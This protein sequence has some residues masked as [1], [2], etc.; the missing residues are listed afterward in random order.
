MNGILDP[1]LPTENISRLE[2]LKFRTNPLNNNQVDVSV[3]STNSTQKIIIDE[4][5][6]SVSYIGFS[7]IGSSTANPVWRI[8]KITVS[9]TI[10]ELLHA[11]GDGAYDNIWDNRASLTYS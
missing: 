6:T 9:G 10:T 11:D 2:Q 5:S 1:N 3:T 7:E 4:V 8:L